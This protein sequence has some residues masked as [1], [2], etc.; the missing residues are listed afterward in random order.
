VS[1]KKNILDEEVV[2][3]AIAE[4][5]AEAHVCPVSTEKEDFVKGLKIAAHAGRDRLDVGYC[6]MIA[7]LYGDGRQVNLEEVCRHQNSTA[8]LQKMIALFRSAKPYWR[9]ENVS[10]YKATK[11]M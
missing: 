2:E 9:V 11:I 6:N 7:L 4:S 5:P 8:A 1:K 10:P 3:P